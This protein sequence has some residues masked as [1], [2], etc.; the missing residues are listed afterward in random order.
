MKTRFILTLAI[1]TTLCLAACRKTQDEPNRTNYAHERMTFWT[2]DSLLDDIH[3]RDSLR[4]HIEDELR[5]LPN[6]E[7]S[8]Q[9][10]HI[11]ASLVELCRIGLDFEGAMNYCMEGTSLAAQMG[12]D[13]MDAFFQNNMGDMFFDAEELSEAG[14]QYENACKLL[15]NK[16]DA[17]LMKT[18]S[19]YALDMYEFEFQLMQY[20]AALKYIKEAIEH[21]DKSYAADKNVWT[22][23]E[24]D[25][26][27]ATALID[28]AR[29]MA[30]IDRNEEGRTYYEQF[31]QS[32]FA[33]TNEGIYLEIRYLD[34][35]KDWEKA[36]ERYSVLEERV[37]TIHTYN[38]VTAFL[39]RLRFLKV[40]IL[41][42]LERWKECC[43]AYDL[44]EDARHFWTKRSGHHK[45]LE[46]YERYG[47]Q[48][49][50]ALSADVKRVA[51]VRKW[52]ITV[53]IVLLCILIT[54]CIVLGRMQRIIRS[55]NKVLAENVN[56]MLNERSKKTAENK[57]NTEAGEL[58]EQNKQQAEEDASK[59][60]IEI[61]NNALNAQNNKNVE[62]FIQTLT[63]QKLF[64]ASDF[65]ASKLLDDL[66]IPYRPFPA[67]FEAYTGT[68]IQHY[69]NHL[70]LEHAAEL[71]R[72]KPDYTLEAIAEESGFS[73]RST[74]NRNF[75][76]LYGITPSEYKK[77]NQ[78]S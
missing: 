33:K 51:M 53:M 74:F 15:E 12:N 55:K 34:R 26:I 24:Y 28:M 6:D 1:L 67:S 18:F 32:D 8:E 44:Y 42:G 23:T 20:D 3:K 77:Q 14:A 9:R 73:I 65:K 75:T 49:E 63:T 29:L 43:E 17:R 68:T 70:R 7:Q 50:Q 52:V 41:T 72:N 40:R 13:E 22:E 57:D 66:H 47:V 36:L 39:P 46:S 2:N 10:L 45:I 78:V 5:K 56:R 19:L 60:N 58:E 61:T 25:S 35:A 4:T 31:L 27:H 21:I 48:R 38:S 71:I 37:D 16:T 30:R 69:I 64:C 76:R 54:L 62:L 11:L 59:D